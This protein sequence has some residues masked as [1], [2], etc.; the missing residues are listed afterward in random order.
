MALQYSLLFRCSNFAVCV[1]CSGATFSRFFFLLSFFR[2]LRAATISSFAMSL[3]SSS[4][5]V[6]AASSARSCIFCR[7]RSARNVRMAPCSSLSKSSSSSTLWATS[8]SE[9]GAKHEVLLYQSVDSSDSS[10]LCK[11]SSSVKASCNAAATFLTC[12]TR[13]RSVASSGRRSA[14]FTG[15]QVWCQ[16]LATTAEQPFYKHEDCYPSVCVAVFAAAQLEASYQGAYPPSTPQ[17]TTIGPRA[18]HC[19]LSVISTHETAKKTYHS[20][21][22]TT[23][24]TPKTT[25]TSL[26]TTPGCFN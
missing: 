25:T 26:K 1:C 4:S 9:L 8:I 21:I 5:F 2:F 11:K 16:S 6:R 13:T 3:R 20:S 17:S 22:R 24:L 23:L 15:V 14:V 12:C 7:V 10:T 19:R 18:P